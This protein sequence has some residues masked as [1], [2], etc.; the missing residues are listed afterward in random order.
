M[1]VKDVFSKKGEMN[2]VY[3]A[4]LTCAT[5]QAVHLICMQRVLLEPL[6]ASREEEELPS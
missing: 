4:L 2:K 3:I 6:L 1:D 5:N